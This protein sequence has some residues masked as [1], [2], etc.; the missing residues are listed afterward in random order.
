MREELFV[1]SDDRSGD[2]DAFRAVD[3][4]RSVIRHDRADRRSE[5]HSDLFLQLAVFPS[6]KDLKRQVPHKAEWGVRPRSAAF[7]EI[8]FGNPSSHAFVFQRKSS[9]SV[10]DGENIPEPAGQARSQSFLR[11]KP[12]CRNWSYEALGTSTKYGSS[13]WYLLRE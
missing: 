6:F 9:A 8:V 12:L 1:E 13:G 7:T 3:D 2:D 11:R 5:H 4:E 10:R